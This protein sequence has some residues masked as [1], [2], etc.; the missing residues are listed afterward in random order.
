MKQHKRKF[1]ILMVLG[2]VIIWGSAYPAVR[3]LIL[4]GVDPYLITCLRVLFSLVFAGC[5]VAAHRELPDLPAFRAH[6]LPFTLMG[7]IGSAAFLLLMNLGLEH[8]EAGKSSLI[9]GCNPVYIVLMS[10]FFL[11]EPLGKR[12]L[13]GII[14][15][16]AGVCLTVSGADILAGRQIRF[17]P[18]DLILLLAGLFWAAYTI[19]NRHY[20]HYLSYYQGLF[21]MFAVST[22]AISP[23]LIARFDMLAELTAR[24]W[25]WSAYLG[26]VPGGLGYLLWNRGLNTIGASVCGMLNCF[27]P[28]SSILLSMIFL[29][30]S[31][32]WLQLIGGALVIF[33]VWQGLSSTALPV[34]YETGRSMDEEVS[35]NG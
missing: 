20:G 27:L 6:A 23:L 19:I 34:N 30:E 5:S 24:Q 25:F 28:V 31:L 22:V 17:Y 33:G 8:C 32:V 29:N 10:Y 35:V 15:A 21:W 2:T 13:I 18:P 3:F 26:V 4:D 1:Y 14:I 16:A 11:K 9:V 7:L 12:K